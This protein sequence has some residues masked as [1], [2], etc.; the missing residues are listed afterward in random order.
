MI[1]HSIAAFLVTAAIHS[2]SA[3][4]HADTTLLRYVNP[5]IGTTNFGTTNPGALMPNGLMSVTPFNV[6]GSDMNR[7]DKDARWWSTPYDAT[8][9]FLTGFSHVNLSG[10]GCPELGS[11]VTMATTGVLNPDFREYGTTYHDE[12]A[13]PGYYSVRLDKYGILSEVTATTRSSVERYT[14]PA[15]QGNILVNLGIGL[16]NETGGSIR[17]ISDTEITGSRLMGTFCYNPDAVFTMYFALRVNKKPSKSGFWKKQPVMHGVE[18]EWTPD[19]G[20]YKIYNS[21][22]R[23]MSGDDLGYWFTYDNLSEGEQIE[24]SIGVSFVS[25]KCRHGRYFR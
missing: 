2:V 9:C 22:N 15:G 8:N 12:K 19:N 3:A 1:R 5:F 24:L 4:E 21:Y 23:E 18:A 14:F 6:T 7:F 20:T 17:R 13:S 16:S 11:V 10:V 25:E